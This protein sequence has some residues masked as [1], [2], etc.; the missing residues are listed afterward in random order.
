MVQQRVFLEAA[1][2]C[3]A[4]QQRQ[5]HVADH[6]LG[7]LVARDLERLEPVAGPQ[8]VMPAGLQQRLDRRKILFA[9]VGQQHGS[10]RVESMRCLAG[11]TNGDRPRRGGASQIGGGG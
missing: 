11:R 7:P 3:E 5:Q 10:H 1:A 9:L 6:R 4:V 2:E 8:H